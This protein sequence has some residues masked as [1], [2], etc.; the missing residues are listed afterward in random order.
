VT[1]VLPHSYGGR[2]VLVH[3]AVELVNNS[4]LDLAVGA[5]TPLL[6]EPQGS[7]VVPQG[8]STWLPLQVRC[9]EGWP[10]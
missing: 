6:G 10:G 1:Q 4:G 8:K 3:S 7:E 9:G 5:S 2:L